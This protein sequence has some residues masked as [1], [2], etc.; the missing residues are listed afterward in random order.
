MN[1]TFLLINGM[2]YPVQYDMLELPLFI[3]QLIE[4]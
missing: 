4:N 2:E 3:E 1:C